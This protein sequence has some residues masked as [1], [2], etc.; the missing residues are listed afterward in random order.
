M[1]LHEAYSFLRKYFPNEVARS[2]G[3]AS[4]LC[5]VLAETGQ[6]LKLDGAV[7]SVTNNGDR[8]IPKLEGEKANLYKGD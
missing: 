6:T 7:F 3:L 8:Q 5:C 2:S 1:K 4:V